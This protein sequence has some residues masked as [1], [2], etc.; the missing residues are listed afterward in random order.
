MGF[1]KSGNLVRPVLGPAQGPKYGFWALLSRNSALCIEIACQGMF[2][3]ILIYFRC[4]EPVWARLRASPRFKIWILSF[5]WREISFV[6]SNKISSNVKIKILWIFGF[7]QVWE[8]TVR[9]VK[10]DTK[11]WSYISTK[12]I[13]HK[14]VSYFCVCIATKM[15]LW[16]M[17]QIQKKLF[18]NLGDTSFSKQKIACIWPQI[19]DR[20]G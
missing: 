5:V 17:Y 19:Y 12:C 2:S 16:E 18:V 6:H 13:S 15:D 7:Y 8:S 1:T 20:G 3:T 9:L 4:Q 11:F 14:K 10:I